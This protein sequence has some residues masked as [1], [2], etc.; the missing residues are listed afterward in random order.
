LA[1]GRKQLISDSSAKDATEGMF[2]KPCPC[3]QADK[4]NR[5]TKKTG[6]FKTAFKSKKLHNK[7]LK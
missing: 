6:S 2:C 1:D 3:L 7:A 5:Q 4:E